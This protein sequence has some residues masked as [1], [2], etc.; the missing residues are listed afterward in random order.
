M[1][2]TMTWQQE[3]LDHVNQSFVL[4]GLEFSSLNDFVKFAEEK[5]GR[6]DT[7]VLAFKRALD[8]ASKLPPESH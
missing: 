5:L 4:Y 7:T 8:E 2:G 3:V 6:G 1:G